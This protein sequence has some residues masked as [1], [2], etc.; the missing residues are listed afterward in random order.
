MRLIIGLVILVIVTAAVAAEN[1]VAPYSRYSYE[2][3][4]LPTT[5]N[6]MKACFIDGRAYSGGMIAVI[7]ERTF[8]CRRR[9]NSFGDR[10]SSQQ[11]VWVEDGTSP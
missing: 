9:L 4:S 5:L 2:S 3:K 1:G 6:T 11:L 8:K 10:A 7:R